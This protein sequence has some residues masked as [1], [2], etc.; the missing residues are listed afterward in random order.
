MHSIYINK[1]VY[2]N[3]P[4]DFPTS[5]KCGSETYPYKA[6]VSDE[7][8]CML[9]LKYNVSNRGFAFTLPYYLVKE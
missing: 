7:E 6:E 9:K 2:K 1:D 4:C 3:N 5:V 8:L